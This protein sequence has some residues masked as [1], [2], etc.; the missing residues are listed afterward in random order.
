M[1]RREGPR[2]RLG[3]TVDRGIA[4]SLLGLVEHGVRRRPDI[5]SALR[6]RVVFRFAEPL[7]PV[8]IGFGPRTI[9]VEDGDLR[10]P[11]LAI[12]GSLPDIVHLTTAPHV[13][14]VPNP[15]RVRGRAALARVARR[16]VRISG[17]RAMARALLRLLS[18]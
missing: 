14:G 13:R 2:V 1:A 16:R 11:D 9:T 3:R 12:E 17:D 6:G 18:L 4:P 7:A 5:A 15:A 10:K 8:R